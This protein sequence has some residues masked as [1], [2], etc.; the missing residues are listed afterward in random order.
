VIAAPP[1][2]A[3]RALGLAVRDPEWRDA[4][5]GDLREEF[6]LMTRRHG[7]P[8][9]RRW[10]WVQAMGIAAHRAAAR[11]SP[12]RRSA[13]LASPEPPDP[14]AG[15]VA[16]LGHDLRAAWRSLRH[17]PAL[18]ATVVV[19]LALGLA[20][21][22][23][24]FAIADAIVLRPFR[25]PGVERAAIVAS[26]AHEAFYDRES[27]APGDFLDW[28][29]Q[30][31]GI[32][33]RLA[34]VEWWDPQLLPDGPPQQLTGFKVS[35]ELF[36]IIGEAPLLGR[37]LD[38]R[39]A[40]A[41]R[42]VVVVGYEF[43]RRQLG[44]RR[45][46]VG[47]QLRLDGV[48]REVVGVMPA[49]FR[50]PHGADVW[51]PLVLE[52]EARAE[53]A[54]GWLIVVGRLADGMDAG[55]AEQR[56]QAIV[57]EQRRRFPETHEKRLV[58]VFGFTEGLGDAAAGP[59]IVVWQIAAV[60][61]LLVAC[62]NVANLLLARNTEREREFAVRLA[63]GASGGRLVAQL[64]VEA[65]LL[66][67]LAT[68]LALPLAWAAL[69]AI[70]SMFPDA[71]IR[72]VPGWSFLALEPRAFLATSALAAGAVVLFATAPALRAARQNVT[73]GLR[74][75][76]RLTA[77][78]GRQRARAVLASA[79]IAL[80]LA[81]LVAAGLSLSALYRVTEGP[82]GF[83]PANVLVGQIGLPAERYGDA[84]A[85]RQFI[86]RVLR[87]IEGLPAVTAVG[88]T[89]V[90]PYS[91]SDA[92][93]TFWPEEVPARPGNA[94]QIARRRVTPAIFT[95]LGIPLLEGR[96][97]AERDRADAPPVA[98]VSRS[99]AAR[100]WPGRPAIGRRFRTAADGPLVTV[101]GVVGDVAQH[102]LVDPVRPSFYLPY[103]QDPSAGVFVV[104]KTVT[105]PL[106]LAAG[107]RVAV[108]AADAG[109][110]VARLQ[111]MEGVIED[112]TVGLR[113]AGRTLGVIAAVSG[114]LSAVGIYSLMAFLTGRRT[115]E[116]G[117]RMALGATRRDV[118][119]LAVTQA[120]RLVL[121][122]IGGGLVLAF[123]VGRGLES[124]MFGVVTASATLPVVLAALLAATALAASYLPARRVSR[125]EPT[126]A[127]RSE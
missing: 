33:D 114:L 17:Q 70:R 53:R 25:Y 52:P 47:S 88:I 62:A 75:G 40:L 108:Q 27:V 18:S 76:G 6:L 28:R 51:A 121:A 123:F 127:L 103:D 32:F 44:G 3:E 102:W 35:P 80:T 39:D 79:Q 94:M 83:D 81:L 92:S 46:A 26:D 64:L 69:G 66:A 119:R 9:A 7:L 60:V 117:V 101:V 22:A 91:G 29:E 24:I 110:P 120:L 10:Y 8:V 34:A 111:T 71:I 106:Q 96:L 124:A 15:R 84:E 55:R 14:H 113:F 49:S 87:R 13:P 61:L 43:W 2:L 23:T 54:R 109:L 67:A 105:D 82:L 78:A 116:M 99:L 68:G 118:V 11:L 41:D 4:I 50:V 122:G 45:D 58:S 1:A 57:A 5:L 20:A 16:W 30:T 74:P 77:G 42:P 100:I 112:G 86:A 89:S 90:L 73:D 93:T 12:A 48:T 31:G 19:V 56:M 126:I 98:V 36:E 95:A 85:R 59:F 125:V 115:R 72:F 107:L 65:G 97:I 37:P 104:V 63:L 38:A 21:N